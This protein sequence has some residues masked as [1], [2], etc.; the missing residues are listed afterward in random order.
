MPVNQQ[1]IGTFC[2]FLL[3]IVDDICFP[4]QIDC[5]LLFFCFFCSFICHCPCYLLS[6]QIL[7][8]HIRM[9]LPGLK[10]DLNSH[11]GGIVK[12]LRTYGDAMESKVS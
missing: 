12:E 10:A 11:M 1:V 4:F 2:F 5:S 9:V 8:Q 3:V 6:F 7:E